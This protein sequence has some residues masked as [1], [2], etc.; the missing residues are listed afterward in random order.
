MWN[1]LQN[2]VITERSKMQNDMYKQYVATVKK[3]KDAYTYTRYTCSG[4]VYLRKV[5]AVAFR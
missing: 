5:T 2:T 1:N 4:S 3:K